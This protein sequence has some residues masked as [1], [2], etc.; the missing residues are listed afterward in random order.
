[1]STRGLVAQTVRVAVVDAVSLVVA[2]ASV[3]VT[4]VVRVIVMTSSA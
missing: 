3:T 1:M 2:A 4:M